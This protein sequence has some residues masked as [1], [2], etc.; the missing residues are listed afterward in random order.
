MIVLQK[1]EFMQEFT[2]AINVECLQSNL[3]HV[4]KLLLQTTH[5]QNM[6]KPIR[7]AYK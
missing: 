7:L 2:F 1:L 3:L 5:I 4:A 6:Q